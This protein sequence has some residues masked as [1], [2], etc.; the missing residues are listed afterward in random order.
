M[1]TKSFEVCDGCGKEQPIPSSWTEETNPLKQWVR[2]SLDGGYHAE[3]FCPACVA[4]K[5]P[6]RYIEA[7]S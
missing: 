6:Q 3:E 5:K 2:V 1:S 4:D 7:H